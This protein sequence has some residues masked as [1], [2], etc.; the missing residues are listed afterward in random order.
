MFPRTANTANNTLQPRHLESKM[1]LIH[2]HYCHNLYRN[3]H[4][5]DILLGDM[6]CG[7]EREGAS[8]TEDHF[9]SDGG[10]LSRFTVPA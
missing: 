2:S 9:Q 6:I 8:G 4:F 10:R 3:D 5:E 1:L 7:N